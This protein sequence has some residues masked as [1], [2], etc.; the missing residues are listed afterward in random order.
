MGNVGGDENTLA[1]PKKEIVLPKDTVFDK[2]TRLARLWPIFGIG[3]L[4]T[5][6]L[7]VIVFLVKS[8]VQKVFQL[9][10]AIPALFKR[11]KKA[12]V[13][14]IIEDLPDPEV[15]EAE[16]LPELN[17]QEVLNELRTKDLPKSSS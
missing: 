3:C 13:E 1:K 17:E 11:K 9:L 5:T 8:V 14:D 16:D 4:I 15:I 12:P 6:A 2:L 7:L 10:A